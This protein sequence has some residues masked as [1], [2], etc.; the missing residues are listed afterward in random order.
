MDLWG[1]YQLLQEQEGVYTRFWGKIWVSVCPV[2][3]IYLYIY[4]LTP[5]RIGWEMWWLTR[6]IDVPSEAVSPLNIS[7]GTYRTG[8]GYQTK[9]GMAAMAP[10]VADLS[11]P[12]ERDK[13]ETGEPRSRKDD[14]DDADR[15]NHAVVVPRDAELGPSPP[16]GEPEKVLIIESGPG[17]DWDSDPDNPYNWSLGK[18]WAQV[19]MAASFAG[20]S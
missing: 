18:S 13:T 2:G 14:D 19:A 8:R 15:T 20:L 10:V 12:D 5:R 17:W 3:S 11:G 16:S 4:P 7:V 6:K 1:A 9:E